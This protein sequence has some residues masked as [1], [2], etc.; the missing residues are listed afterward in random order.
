M[1]ALVIRGLDPFRRRLDELDDQI[2][3]LLGERF[4]VC[5]QVAYYKSK[6]GVAMMQPNRVAQVRERYLERGDDAHLP[7]DFTSNLFELVIDATCQM[8]DDLMGTPE[9]ERATPRIVGASANG[10]RPS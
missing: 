2:V 6:H 7:E 8:E 5:R 9:E 1:G 4:E 10:A 3:R